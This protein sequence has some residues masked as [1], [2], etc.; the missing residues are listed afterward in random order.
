[1]SKMKIHPR[2]FQEIP[3]EL[4]Y[5]NAKGRDVPEGLKKLC[6][7]KL[8][9][10]IE[11][12]F[13]KPKKTD[14]EGQVYANVCQFLGVDPLFRLVVRGQDPKK[15]PGLIKTA[16]ENRKTYEGKGY[17]ARNGYLPEDIAYLKKREITRLKDSLKTS[18]TGCLDL[19]WEKNQDTTQSRI[20]N[21]VNQHV[22]IKRR[23]PGQK[24][25]PDV[26]KTSAQD[27]M[28][29]LTEIRRFCGSREQMKDY[30][31][32]MAAAKLYECALSNKIKSEKEDPKTTVF[33]FNT[34]EVYTEV[35]NVA[36][37]SLKDGRWQKFMPPDMPGAI[38]DP[39]KCFVDTKGAFCKGEEI[40]FD[41]T[42]GAW[43]QDTNPN[44][45]L[46]VGQK[47]NTALLNYSAQPMPQKESDIRKIGNGLNHRV[48]F[49]VEFAA[50]YNKENS[51]KNKEGR[52]LTPSRVLE[53]YGWALC[54]D[55]SVGGG[56]LKS[57]VL[58]FKSDKHTD[59]LIQQMPLE[60]REFINNVAK[61][62]HCGGH[63]N[64]S[65]GVYRPLNC[66]MAISTWGFIW[67]LLYDDRLTN[68]KL[69]NHAGYHFCDY[70]RITDPAHKYQWIRLKRHCMEIRVFDAHWNVDALL[71]RAKLA[72]MIVQD[73]EKKVTELRHENNL[74]NYP[75]WENTLIDPI[76]KL[77]WKS[78]QN[79]ENPIREHLRTTITRRAIAEK[80]ASKSYQQRV[81]KVL[82][83]IPTPEGDLVL[84]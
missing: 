52:P 38:K 57:P 14:L 40:I 50:A 69:V 4:F 25:N 43:K 37:S 63:L 47:V 35:N 46:C 72:A 78:F 39:N 15:E 79:P 32:M 3:G 68:T 55:S 59:Q 77:N 23:T 7:R 11:L 76:A 13:T 17:A 75:Y 29:L 53:D 21:G 24:V 27:T 67:P 81:A 1:M 80:V 54:P 60:I 48:G 19:M 71:W 84:K 62:G 65:H 51:I 70:R 74:L 10:L 16:L 18:K 2:H 34:L 49:E 56:E 73:V 31:R 33:V 8:Q 45:W 36:E 9:A 44:R 26:Y 42:L 30:H 5:D 20:W 22:Y 64:Y 83:F 41:N 61:D 82:G 12:S 28:E 6:E 66:M 58:Y